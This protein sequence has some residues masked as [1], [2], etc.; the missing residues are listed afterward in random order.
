MSRRCVSLVTWPLLPLFLLL[1]QLAALRHEIEI[2]MRKSVREGCT[3]SS[4]VSPPPAPQ[5]TLGPEGM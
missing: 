4:E 2:R 5:I 1:E 3:V